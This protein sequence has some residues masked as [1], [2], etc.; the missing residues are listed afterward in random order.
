MR[1]LLYREGRR[2]RFTAGQMIQ[3]RGDVSDGFWLVA[4]GKVSIC[5]FAVD[6]TVTV[7]AV[8]GADDLF[9][10]LAHFA[11]ISRQIDAV[12]DSDTELIRVDGRLVD[13]LIGEEPRFARWLLKS[14][15]NQLRHALDR[16]D[17]DSSLGAE[18]RIARAL[19]DIARRDGPDLRITQQGLADLVGVSRVTAGQALGKMAKAGHITLHYRQIVVAD[20][21]ALEAAYSLTLD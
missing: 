5:R 4:A 13:R 18:A 2:H 20:A 19:V 21:P 1:A 6:G 8:L 15:A 9:G 10:E 12:A 7:F 14:L 16:I 11:G 3:Q 17:R